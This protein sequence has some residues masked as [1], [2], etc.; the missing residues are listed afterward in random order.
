MVCVK[1]Q[2]TPPNPQVTDFFPEPKPYVGPFFKAF[3]SSPTSSHRCLV[4]YDPG[5]WLPLCYL[6]WLSAL[7][8]IS[9]YLCMLLCL[10]LLLLSIFFNTL[11]LLYYVFS[12]VDPSSHYPRW[13]RWAPRI[14]FVRS[15]PILSLFLPPFLSLCLLSA[16]G[17]PHSPTYPLSS[18]PPK[19]IVLHRQHQQERLLRRSTCSLLSLSRGFAEQQ[20]KNCSVPDTSIIS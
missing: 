14:Y 11:S 9:V 6:Y 18:A 7:L 15:S 4:P 16:L 13:R 8:P 12:T 2:T 17:Y 3:V 5:S 1:Q 10:S 19:L 20:K